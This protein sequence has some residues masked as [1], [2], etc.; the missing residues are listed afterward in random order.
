MY[1]VYRS[2]KTPPPNWRIHNKKERNYRF[3]FTLDTKPAW[4][5]KCLVCKYWEHIISKL[6]KLF[7]ITKEDKK[8]FSLFYD[9]NIPTIKT[10]TIRIEENT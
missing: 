6:Y 5:E 7:Q 1:N 4:L 3:M 10:E 8:L 2:F 9:I